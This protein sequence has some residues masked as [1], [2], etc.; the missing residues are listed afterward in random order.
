ML[1]IYM[2]I[3]IYMY[4]YCNGNLGSLVQCSPA[5]LFSSALCFKGKPKRAAVHEHESCYLRG[6]DPRYTLYTNTPPEGNV[7]QVCYPSLV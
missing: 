7:T 1:Y 4:A 6:T 3:Y 5:H 2:Y